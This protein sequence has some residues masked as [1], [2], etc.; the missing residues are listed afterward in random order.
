MS[1]G[2]VRLKNDIHVS[3]IDSRQGVTGQSR[4]RPHPSNDATLLS[5]AQLPSRIPPLVGRGLTRMKEV[6][7]LWGLTRMK[8]VGQ[9]WGLTHMK[10]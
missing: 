8:E 4:K 2:I 7:Q 10:V 5:A 3:G 6:G 9:V 1:R